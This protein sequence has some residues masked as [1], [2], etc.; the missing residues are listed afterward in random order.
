MLKE[1]RDEA[2]KD[3]APTDNPGRTRNDQEYSLWEKNSSEGMRKAISQESVTNL[4]TS[5]AVVMVVTLDKVTLQSN[6][7]TATL[8]SA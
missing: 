5:M 6:S 1:S 7:S 2:R 3:L 4:K 8:V